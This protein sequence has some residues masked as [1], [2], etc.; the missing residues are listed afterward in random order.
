MRIWERFLQRV[1]GAGQR[2][3]LDDEMAF[4]LEAL[5]QDREGLP[6]AHE[7]REG[8]SGVFELGL[9]QNEVEES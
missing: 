7:P 6:L 2:A 9:A 5:A 3:E 8:W 4:H 1:R